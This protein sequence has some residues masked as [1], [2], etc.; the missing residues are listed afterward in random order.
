MPWEQI[1]ECGAADA[2]SNRQWMLAE[3]KLGVY[4]VKLACGPPPA[5]SKVGV[6]EHEHEL[7]SYATVGLCWDPG[8]M[9]DAPWEYIARAERALSRFEDAVSWSDLGPEPDDE[10][11]DEDENDGE[12]ENRD[13]RD[14]DD[15]ASDQNLTGILSDIPPEKLR[16]DLAYKFSQALDLDPEKLLGLSC[17]VGLDSYGDLLD[18]AARLYYKDPVQLVTRFHRFSTIDL[19]HLVSSDP[20]KVADGILQALYS[21]ES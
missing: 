7:G 19:R 11:I 10:E 17:L 5:G 20:I 6:M 16:D 8:Q 2:K 15:D 9:E 4:Y 21:Q 12:D 1:G 18:L 14:D 3:V 13:A